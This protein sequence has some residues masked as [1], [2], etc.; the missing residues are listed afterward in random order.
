MVLQTPLPFSLSFTALP[1]A[2]AVIILYWSLLRLWRSP[3]RDLPYPPGPPPKDLISGNARDISSGKLWLTYT[4]WGKT[5]GD[6]VHFRAF[7]QHVVLLNSFNGATELLEKRSNNY[8]ARPYISMINLRVPLPP[9]RSMGWDFTTAFKP[10]GADWQMH[11]RL[12]QQNFKPNASLGYRPIQT[13][14][15]NDMLY[16]LLASPEDFL[17]HTKTVA[18]AIIMSAIYGYDISPKGDYFVTLAERGVLGL[19]QSAF[20]GAAVVNTLP[21]LRVLPSWFPGAGFK[22]YA[23]SIKDLITQMQ[24]VPYNYV[25]KN[26]VPGIAPPCLVTSLLDDCKS[27]ADHHTVSVI[28]TLF[29]AMATFPDIQRKAQQEIDMVVGSDRLVGYEDQPSLP[30]IQ[31]L[32]REVLRWR[33]VLPLSVAHAANAEDVYKGYY[34]PKGT[35]TRNPA[36]TRD[37]VKYEHPELFNPDRFLDRDGNL[38]DDDMTYTFGFGRRSVQASSSFLNAISHFGIICPDR[39]MGSA[40][41]WLVIAMVLSTFDIQRKKDASGKDMPIEVEYSDGLISHPLPFECSII[42]KSDNARQLIIEVND[43]M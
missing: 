28:R 16:A 15:V 18:A 14:K 27:E 6:I 35:P 31:A 26:V 33:P 42:P 20:P 10:Y 38:N 25:K 37:P 13:R 43:N 24:E 36:M 4:E 12:L 39:H 41:I 21:F 29:Y 22:R 9:L 23:L 11:R 7:G 34:I 1:L 3:L 19:S 40:T 17:A 30:Y 5:Y 8:S 2:S 32:L